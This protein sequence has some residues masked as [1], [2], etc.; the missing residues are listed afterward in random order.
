MALP[1][2]H[3]KRVF[4]RKHHWGKGI[5]GGAPSAAE[6]C[7]RIA[8]PQGI[9]CSV[10]CVISVVGVVPQGANVMAMGKDYCCDCAPF[11]GSPEN[12]LFR[13]SGT[14]EEPSKQKRSKPEGSME[15]QTPGE[16]ARKGEK[17]TR[18]RETE[19]GFETPPDNSAAADHWTA[20]PGIV[21]W[22]RSD[23]VISRSTMGDLASQQSASQ[24]L[25]STIEGSII[26]RGAQIMGGGQKEAGLVASTDK[27]A[28]QHCSSHTVLCSDG[29]PARV[30]TDPNPNQP[31]PMPSSSGTN[32]LHVNHPP[33]L[34]IYLLPSQLPYPS[35]QIL[36]Q[37][38]EI[39]S[40][41]VRFRSRS[42]I[43]A[44]IRPRD[45]DGHTIADARSDR[46]TFSLCE[47]NNFAIM[48]AFLWS[49]ATHL[50]TTSQTLVA[51]FD[52]LPS[53][54]YA[55]F[56]LERL[57][58]Q[59]ALSK[60]WLP[61]TESNAGHRITDSVRAIRISY[62]RL[63]LQDA[64]VTTAGSDI[65]TGTYVKTMQRFRTDTTPKFVQSIIDLAILLTSTSAIYRQL[66][67]AMTVVRH[68]LAAGIWP[69]LGFIK[70]KNKQSCFWVSSSRKRPLENAR[71]ST[72][73]ILTGT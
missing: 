10:G 69:R 25:P 65:D 16:T 59:P 68:S 53:K 30:Y 62:T 18:G 52:E 57:P 37:I 21:E 46:M 13:T 42:P 48:R 14:D 47:F 49:P 31:A 5:T 7:N 71:P 44:L 64:W 3:R 24:L 66:I 39:H 17:G 35:S 56:V 20:Q 34:P 9:G 23:D 33:R 2:G 32:T 43:M 70:S 51:T 72:P 50:L 12:W 19:A 67:Q 40:E 63:G 4:F 41:S 15:K 58:G 26:P 11:G 36:S 27:Q 22:L 29:L 38:P 73:V 45:D 54:S 61:I 60:F 55:Y 28:A 8:T 6:A 1:D